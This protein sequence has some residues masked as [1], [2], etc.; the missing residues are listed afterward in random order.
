MDQ[1]MSPTG[2]AL[3]TLELLQ[4]EPG[5]TAQRLASELEVTERAVRRY[6]ALLREAEIPVDSS[7]GRYGGYWLGRGAR[8][9]P[10]VFSAEE[11][12]ALVMSVLEGG[13]S[14]AD[15]DDPV[16][17]ALG[18]I[19]R[20]LPNEVARPAATVRSHAA[21]VQRASSARPATTVTSALVTAVADRRRVSLDYRSQSGREWTE[22]VDPWAVIVRHGYWYLLCYSGRASE[23]RA[24]RVDRI[25]S[26]AALAGRSSAPE[27]VDFPAL[28][29]EQL[30]VG[31][32]FGT[33]VTFDAPV[34]EVARYVRPPMGRLEPIGDGSR[35]R[36]TGST[37]N[38]DMYAGEWLAAIPLQFHVDGGEE[39]R[40]AVEALAGRFAA[41]VESPPTRTPVR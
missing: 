17:A 3:R 15:A 7:R 23:V 40:Q 26:V 13:H 30:G 6:I 24:Y 22:E 31:W 18:K 1:A 34:E 37:S 39:L 19:I 33:E 36:L 27:G 20:S 9:P 29:E 2:R 8:L 12:L 11:A 21:A 32:E 14:A 10:L 25:S 16:G 41:S 38:P 5:I 35:S 4:A 28:L